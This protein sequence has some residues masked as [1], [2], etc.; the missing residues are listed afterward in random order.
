LSE[1]C[2]SAEHVDVALVENSYVDVMLQ[3]VVWLQL[4]KLLFLVPENLQE[5]VEVLLQVHHYF[6][7]PK[8][9]IN[10]Y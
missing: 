3:L 8:N 6:L 9:M 2:L 1:E 4:G 7:H 10:N 5:L